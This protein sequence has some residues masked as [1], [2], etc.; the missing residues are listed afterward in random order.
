MDTDLI[1]HPGFGA[2]LTGLLLG[3]SCS[4]LHYRLLAV[5]MRNAIIRQNKA[6]LSFVAGTMLRMV[7]LALPLLTAMLIPRYVSVLTAFLGLMSVKLYF[8]FREMINL[9]RR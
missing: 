1:L 5:S 2:L 9:K 8:F 6:N 7:I 4:M 3:S